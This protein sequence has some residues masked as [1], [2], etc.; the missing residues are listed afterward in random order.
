MNDDG[1]FQSKEISPGVFSCPRGLVQPTQLGMLLVAR[2]CIPY[3]V[4]YG[5]GLKLVGYDSDTMI[6]ELF[7]PCP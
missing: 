2:R 1:L 7:Q 6:I 5:K 3:K 4:R